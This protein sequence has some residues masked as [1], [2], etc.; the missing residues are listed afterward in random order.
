MRDKRKQRGEKTRQAILNATEEIINL[1]NGDSFSTR[2]IAQKANISQSTLYHH[3]SGVEEILI[4]CLKE[5]AIEAL[6]T[7]HAKNFD[8]LHKYLEFLIQISINSLQAIQNV[9]LAVK[10][11]ANRRVINDPDFRQMLFDMGLEFIGKLKLIIRT[12]FNSEISE[13]RLDLAVY[14]FSMFRD[15]FIGHAQLYRD[16]SPFGNVKEKAGNFLQLLSQY[17]IKG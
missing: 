5:R 4:S 17:I 7:D 16:E 14:T 1:A 3:F 15:G 8:C 6:K 9:A 13:E 12:F 2:T 11:K 10:E